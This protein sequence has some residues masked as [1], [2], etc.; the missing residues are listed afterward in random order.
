MAKNLDTNTVNVLKS[1]IMEILA[2]YWNS[3]GVEDAAI[4]RPTFYSAKKD[5]QWFSFHA[6]CPICQ[7][8]NETGYC[9]IGVTNHDPY[10]ISIHCKR[11]P[12]ALPYITEEDGKKYIINGSDTYVMTQAYEEDNTAYWVLVEQGDNFDSSDD[13]DYD[14]EFLEKQYRQAQEDLEWEEEHPIYDGDGLTDSQKTWDDAVNAAEEM[15]ENLDDDYDEDDYDSEEDLQ[16]TS[17][18]LK[19]YYAIKNNNTGESKIVYDTWDSI[20]K[21]YRGK[22][23]FLPPE[24]FDTIAAAEEYI[25]DANSGKP[26]K[27]YLIRKTDGSSIV[28]YD[29]WNNVDKNYR[30][31]AGIFPPKKITAE[32]AEKYLKRDN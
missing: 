30:N 28:V 12:K 20:D 3:I 10:E 21:D 15:F 4:L 9:L 13:I 5:T 8:R 14:E 29:T 19:R 6:Q 1:K 11:L 24:G 7:N 22:A 31:R 27:Y 18:T 32:E 2:S 17:D 23:G 16:S 26:K 25:K